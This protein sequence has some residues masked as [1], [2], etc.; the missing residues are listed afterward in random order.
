MSG[1]AHESTA[2]QLDPLGTLSGRRLAIVGASLA[3]LYAVTMTAR[4]FG[5]L[6]HPVAATLALL[7][8]AAACLA[9][10]LGG[11]PRFAPFTRRRMAFVLTAALLAHLLSAYATWRHNDFVRDDWGPVAVG[12]LLLAFAPFRPW[13]EI[14]RSGIAAA[15]VVAALT[16]VQLPYFVTA[17]PPLV[18]VS[19]AMAPVLGMT[20][21]SATFCRA[22][23]GSVKEWDGRATRAREADV[24]RVREGMARSVQ[25]DRVTILNRDVLP[26]LTEVLDRDSITEDDHER[27]RRISDSIRGV[28]ISEAGRSWLEDLLLQHRQEAMLAGIAQDPPVS[29]PHKVAEFM[30]LE[31]R[32]ALRALLDDLLRTPALQRGTLA[33]RLTSTGSRCD[34]EVAAVL[35]M[36][37]HR[38]RCLISPYLAVFRTAF[39]GVRVERIDTELVLRFSYARH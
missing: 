2:Q 26:F 18:L 24:G 7:A 23:V 31:Q 5:D 14:L 21:A 16:V 30:D 20:V 39:D 4:E 13:A 12:V 33:I 36:S 15:V 27:A 25:Q 9:L 29:D 8:L 6:V 1:P 17:A 28:M 34:A 11:D 3:L 22:L 35:R 37:R 10:V 19:A 38:A 32:A